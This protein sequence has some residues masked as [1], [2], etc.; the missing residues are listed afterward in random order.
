MIVQDKEAVNE[1][2]LSTEYIRWAYEMQ[3]NHNTMKHNKEQKHKFYIIMLKE[4]FKK[5][6]HYSKPMNQLS[7]PTH[8]TK[9]NAQ[10]LYSSQNNK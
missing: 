3:R 10:A 6:Y 9:W 1:L 2:S 4:F 5:E 7:Y 8:S